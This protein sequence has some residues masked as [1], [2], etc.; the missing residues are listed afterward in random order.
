MTDR[1]VGLT[2]VGVSRTLL[3]FHQEKPSPPEE[4]AARRGHW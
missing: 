1:P 4:R 3:T 2:R